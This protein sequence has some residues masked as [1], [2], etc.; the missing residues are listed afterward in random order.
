LEGLEGGSDVVELP[1]YSP[2]SFLFGFLS[3]P[4]EQVNST[5]VFVVILLLCEDIVFEDGRRYELRAPLHR[6]GAFGSD[7]GGLHLGTCLAIFWASKS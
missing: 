7:T 4:Q 3:I 2:S 1:L 5:I 6:I